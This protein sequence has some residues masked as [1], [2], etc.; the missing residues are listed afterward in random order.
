MSVLPSFMHEHLGGKMGAYL[1]RKSTL[2]PTLIISVCSPLWQL[3][4]FSRSV[5]SNS[6][7]PCGLQHIRLL[8]PSLSPGVCSNSCP[9]SLMVPT[10]HLILCHPL[11]LL[12]SI[13]PSIR[14]FPMSRLFASRGQSIGASASVSVLPMNFLDWFPLVVPKQDPTIFCLPWNNPMVFM[15]NA[16]SHQPLYHFLW[17]LKFG[18]QRSSQQPILV[19]LD[20]TR[21]SPIGTFFNVLLFCSHWMLKPRTHTLH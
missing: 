7:Q 19:D 16:Q 3:L 5:V 1:R 21:N 8:F 20:T 2:A 11:L 12:P 14:S 15:V 9:L 18:C 10:K 6:L 17:S 13:F 4:L